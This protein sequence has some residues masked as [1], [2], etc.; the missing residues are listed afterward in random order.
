MK[1][2]E[3]AHDEHARSL[4]KEAKAGS[5]FAFQQLMDQY[6]DKI[7]RMVY[8]RVRSRMDAE[9]LTQDIFLKAYRHLSKLDGP[10]AFYT[11]LFRIAVNRVKDYHRKKKFRSLFGMI[12]VDEEAMTAPDAG[13]ESSIEKEIIRKDFWKQIGKMLNRLSPKEREV[14]LFRFFDQL[15]IN[16]ISVSLGKSQSTVKTHLYRAIE[17]FRNTAMDSTLFQEEEII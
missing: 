14:F 1:A 5:R 17:K 13:D 6:Q 10:E 8:Y 2:S 16:E 15:S 3:R 7:Y 4:V 9:D 12:S 11:W